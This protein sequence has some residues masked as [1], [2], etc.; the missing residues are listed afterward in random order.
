MQ[1]KVYIIHENDEWTVHL[2]KRLDELKLPY[3]S[4][5][6]D[7][8]MLN[9]NKEPPR[10]V[11]YNRMSASSHTRGHRYA[12]EFTGAVIDWLEFYNR[13]IFNG[14]NALRFEI[15]K[16]KQY[17]HLEKEGIKTPKTLAALGKEEILKAAEELNTFPFIIKHNRAGRGLGVNLFK[18][19]NELD[20]YINSESFEDSIDGISLIQEYIKCP[21]AFIIR[22]EFIGQKYLYSVKVD[23]LGG[24]ELCPADSCQIGSMFCPVGTAPGESSETGTHAKFE[25]VENPYTELIMKYEDFL[26][27]NNIDV[28]GI[29]FIVDESG[30]AYTYDVNTNTN[31]NTQAEEKAGIFA[32]LELAKFLAKELEAVK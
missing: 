23:T 25:I 2:T 10:G 31:Y 9:L 7:K 17:T 30:L 22:S 15:N 29:E 3:E 27:K 4:W 6:L 8:G 13:K 32:M 14:S 28:A 21:G 11:F 18:S 26:V 20:I 16:V 5:H 12:P 24:F 1:K 19:I